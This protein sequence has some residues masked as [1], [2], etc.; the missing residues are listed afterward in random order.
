VPN[1][2][3]IASRDTEDETL[4]RVP[5]SIDSYGRRIT[6]VEDSAPRPNYVL[7]FGGSYAFGEGVNDDETTP[8]YVSK[9]A[10]DYRAYNYGVGGYG[11]QHMLANLQRENITAEIEE[12]QGLLIYIF[13]NEH[14]LRAIGSMGIHVQRGEVMPYYYIDTDG[15]LKRNGDLVSGRPVL[16]VLYNVVGSSQILKFFHFDLPLEPGD[17]DFQ[18]TARI[19][20]EARNVY[21]EK[22]HNDQFYVL[23][24]PG[25]GVPE[26]LP[27]L[28][29]AGVKYLDYSHLPQMYD[30][31][32]WLGEGHP[33]AKAHRLV[34]EKLVQELGLQESAEK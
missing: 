27:Y 22:F 26:L 20:E 4:Y 29:A 9:V 19:I 8:Y 3:V 7:F 5:Y 34:A 15:K 11:P 24:F 23:I 33:T 28:D 25:L 16:S 14:V 30:E 18:T 21:R 10:P 31:D 6:P 32:F 13:I 17:R 2:Q 1:T 12:S